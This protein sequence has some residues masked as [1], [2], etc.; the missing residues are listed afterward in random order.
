M[1]DCR[2]FMSAV[3]F[4]F[5]MSASYSSAQAPHKSDLEVKV[6]L[7][8]LDFFVIDKKGNLVTHPGTQAVTAWAVE[9][10]PGTLLQH[11][12]TI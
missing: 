3:S 6:R 10:G 5:A 11:S 1:I 2:R 12:S 9:T 7:M 8:T 4:A